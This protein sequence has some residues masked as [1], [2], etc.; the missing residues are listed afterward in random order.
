MNT[1]SGTMFPSLKYLDAPAAIEWLC[2]TLKFERKLVVPGPDNTIA[3]AQLTLG[4]GM[5]MLGSQ[6]EG[7]YGKHI[8]PPSQIENI[9]T[10]T[11][12][13][14]ISDIDDHYENATSNGANIILPLREEEYGGKHYM[15]S[16]PEGYLWSFGSYDPF[17][18]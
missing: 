8:K 9:N 18:N 11:T 13:I 2:S 4:S 15:C 3:H 5:I 14:Y 6:D 1:T 7:E 16:D 17:S 12:Y 10:Q